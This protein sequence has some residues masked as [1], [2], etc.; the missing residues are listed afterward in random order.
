MDVVEGV[1]ALEA[2]HGRLFFVIGVFDGL[3][4]GH[5]YLLDH[6]TREA[7]DRDARPAVITFDHHPDEVIRG[8]APP[9]L[10]HPAERLDLLAAAGVAV[11]VVQHFDEAVRR[12][13][14]DA[15]V[16]A[17]GARVDLAGFLM[18]PDAAFGFE[19]RGTPEAL[20]ALGRR[21]G[22]DLVVVP[23][24]TLDGRPVRSS[25]IRSAIAAGDL[26][27]ASELLG[28]EVTVTGTARPDGEGTTLEFDMPVALPPAGTYRAST[29][30][31]DVL[32][33][34]GDGGAARVRP[35]VDG[36]APGKP[37]RVVV[38]GPSVAKDQPR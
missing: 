1:E 25:D 6:L 30:G 17:I 19:R 2:G 35:A 5:V 15:F 16:E 13:S 7:A 27:T 22:F 11:T 21:E 9:L 28:R 14:Y 34:V 10:L 31:R 36:T 8:S 29:D 18:T 33:D 12:T 3:H 4:R 20:A 23:P 32:L 24:F 37:L 38:H 26:T